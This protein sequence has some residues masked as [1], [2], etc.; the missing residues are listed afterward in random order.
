MDYVILGLL[1]IRP[2]TNYEIR[3][4]IKL[5]LMLICS[6]SAGS[7]QVSIVKLLK[8]Q[9]ITVDVVREGEIEKKRYSITP[10]G[11]ELF[12]EWVK[13]PMQP[14]KAKKMELSKL[15]FMGFISTHE[16]Q[17]AIEQYIKSLKEI[18]QVF[19]VLQ[20]EF[21]PVEDDVNQKATRE[22]RE[23]LYFQGLTLRYGLDAV[24]FEISWYEKELQQLRSLT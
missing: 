14:E 19:T 16:R 21:A 23:R 10:I 15:F 22:E 7:I 20:K 9:A 6:P 24:V 17:Q 5:N 4:Y 11:E 3:Q 1:L 12:L 8:S 2:M 18:E 13:T